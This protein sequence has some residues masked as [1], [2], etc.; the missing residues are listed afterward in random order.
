MYHAKLIPSIDRRLL[1]R[2]LLPT[3]WTVPA[4]GRWEVDEFDPAEKTSLLCW[5]K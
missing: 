2:L 4:A 1:L 5:I 3:A